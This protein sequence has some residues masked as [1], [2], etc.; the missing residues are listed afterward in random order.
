MTLLC[1]S[2]F[3][4]RYETQHILLW[5][6]QSLG[7]PVPCGSSYLFVHD[8]KLLLTKLIDRIHAH[9]IVIDRGNEEEKDYTA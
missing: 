9:K 4:D 7:L 5:I 1:H 2:R 3:P 8:I 6:M